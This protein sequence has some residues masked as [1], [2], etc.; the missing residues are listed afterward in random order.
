MF[1]SRE[2][3]ALLQE[4]AEWVSKSD[5]LPKEFKGNAANCGIAMEMA[6]R[7]GAGYFQVIQ[8][9][10]VIQGR[11]SFS[12]SF[13]MAMVNACGRFSPLEYR[14]EITGPEKTVVVE[15]SEREGFGNSAKYVTKKLNY[16]YT[17]TTC[18]A[19]ATDLRT[20]K[21]VVGPPVSYDLAISEKWIAKS[22][23]KWQGEM[24]ELMLTYRAGSFFSRV[25]ASDLTLGMQTA[26]ELHDTIDVEA[27]DVTPP[28]Q[29]QAST[30][31][32]HRREAKPEEKVAPA[33]KAA[34][35]KTTRKP[36]A[37]KAASLKDEKPPTTTQR[38][39]V[40]N[41]ASVET[42]TGEKANGES[43][44]KYAVKYMTYEGKEEQASTFSSTIIAP[45]EWADEGA[46]IAI[47]T[48]PSSNP[49]YAPTLTWLEVIPSDDSTAE[50]PDA[51]V[52]Y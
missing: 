50:D 28:R 32:P 11:P 48:T 22:G 9:L 46:R 52:P 19:V 25:Y 38:G 5:L 43:W 23:S 39:T 20:G 41:F 37:D 21:E 49:K 15:Y 47:E 40:V 42:A 16:T 51:E 3:F 44:T 2:C 31:N 29:E 8:N 4:Q 34:P 17:P 45:L 12:A 30:A 26:E 1:T 7:L 18:R 14:M 36:A 13:L 35:P 10:S 33:E 27:R 24:R 6:L